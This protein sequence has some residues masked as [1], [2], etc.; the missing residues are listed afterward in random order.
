MSFLANI[1]RG[2]N[3]SP[4]VSDAYDKIKMYWRTKEKL[5]C[6]LQ[7]HFVKIKAGASMNLHPINPHLSKNMLLE[8]ELIIYK[9]VASDISHVCMLYYSGGSREARSRRGRIFSSGVCFDGPSH[10]PGMCV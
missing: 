8:T 6:P 2:A 10:I 4:P 5:F 1:K 9:E 7:I 3:M